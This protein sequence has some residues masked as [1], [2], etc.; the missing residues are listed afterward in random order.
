MKHY[1]FEELPSCSKYRAITDYVKTKYAQKKYA[2][3][4]ALQT[5]HHHPY[6]E[7]AA[8]LSAETL[9]RKGYAAHHNYAHVAKELQAL[10]NISQI[11]RFRQAAALA[12]QKAYVAGDHH[13]ECPTCGK[14]HFY[15]KMKY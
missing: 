14:M 12:R 7:G 5:T 3:G 2:L 13:K 8:K 15:K 4:L 6:G 1:K 11:D 10:G 9:V